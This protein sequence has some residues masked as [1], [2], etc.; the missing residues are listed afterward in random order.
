[1]A[2]VICLPAPRRPSGRRRTVPLTGVARAQVIGLAARRDLTTAE[3]LEDA[4]ALAN[5]LTRHLLAMARVVHAQLDILDPEVR[6][7]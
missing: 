5:E 6:H 7:D 3:K 1:M 2:K 4:K